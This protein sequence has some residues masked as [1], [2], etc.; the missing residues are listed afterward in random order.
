MGFLLYSQFDSF[1]AQMS[2]VVRGRTRTPGLLNLHPNYADS[3][4][5]QSLLNG[6]SSLGVIFLIFVFV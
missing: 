2:Q 4:E 3:L 5:K 6:K 1:I